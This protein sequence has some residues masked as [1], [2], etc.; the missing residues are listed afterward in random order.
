MIPKPIDQITTQDILAL[1]ENK[2]PE[3]RMLDYKQN[4]PPSIDD[5]WKREFLYD[6]TSFANSAGGEML[7]GITEVRDVNNQPTGIPDQANGIA[8]ENHDKL[9]L[10]LESL[11]RDGVAP[12]MASI[13]IQPINGFSQGA[14][15]VVRIPKSWNAPHMIIFKGL[16]RFYARDNRGKF[17]LDVGQIRQAFLLAESLGENI[18]QFRVDRLNKIIQN[19]LP[20]LMPDGP[21]TILHIVPM[22]SLDK[23]FLI[24][25]TR[26]SKFNTELRPIKAAGWGPQYNFDGYMVCSSGP[27]EERGSYIQI[28]RNGIIEA[29]TTR[30]ISTR[31]ND[32]KVLATMVFEKEIINTLGSYCNVLKKCEIPPPFF[33]MLTITGVKECRLYFGERLFIDDGTHSLNR[34]IMVIPEVIMEDFNTPIDVVI[35]PIFD[36]IWQAAGKERC[37]HYNAEG[38]WDGNQR[39][40]M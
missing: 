18:R 27:A 21:K 13:R 1:V 20:V 33:I 38:R 40:G 19:D 39:S 24:D 34:D 5:E 35:R 28:F 30:L 11:I 9:I 2:V 8:I 12:R 26:L 37:Q 36:L 23:S 31:G 4:I 6:I 17:P 10:S 7:F 14:V 22:A 25:V 29:T 15:L 3:G 32:D 16:S